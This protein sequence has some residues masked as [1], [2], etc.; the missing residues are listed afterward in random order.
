MH[1]SVRNQVSRLSRLRRNVE[2]TCGLKEWRCSNHKI[3]PR[4]R[5]IKIENRQ[6]HRSTTQLHCFHLKLTPQDFLHKLKF[7]FCAADLSRV[8]VLT[9]V[10]FGSYLL[11]PPC[12]VV[13]RRKRRAKRWCTME[14]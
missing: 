12:C 8:K 3:E 7:E 5:K 11:I 10:T 14:A 2:V 9:G 4:L 13:F 1:C 6:V